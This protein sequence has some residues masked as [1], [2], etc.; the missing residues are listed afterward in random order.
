[1]VIVC[2]LPYI[3]TGWKKSLN[4]SETKGLIF[5]PEIALYS[6][7]DGLNAYRKLAQQI[8]ILIQKTKANITLVCEIGHPQKKEI[9]KI[10]SFAKK[11]EF[12]KDLAKKWR[13]VIIKI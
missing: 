13:I 4:S 1:M 2:N 6:G 11:I 10:F 3:D 7:Q 12:Q 8:K 9:E 5:E